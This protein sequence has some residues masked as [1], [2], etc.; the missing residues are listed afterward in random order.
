MNRMTKRLPH[1]KGRVRVLLYGPTDLE[2]MLDAFPGTR[3]LERTVHAAGGVHAEFEIGDAI[4][5]L[6]LND[7]PY[8][9]KSPGNL[10]L[11][12]DDVDATVRD[13]KARGFV[14]TRGPEVRPYGECVASIVDSFGSTWWI[15]SVVDQGQSQAVEPS[16]E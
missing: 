11:Y 12:V 2:P 7:P 13:A 15:C 5:V 8:E 4:V 1:G 14:L 9:G 16:S 3:C 6:E 10:I